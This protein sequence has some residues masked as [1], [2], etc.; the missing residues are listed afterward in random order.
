MFGW[1]KAVSG[2]HV[3]RGI[4]MELKLGKLSLRRTGPITG[5]PH[6][7][8]DNFLGATTFREEGGGRRDAGQGSYH[9]PRE[10][11]PEAVL[12]VNHRQ[13]GD[14]RFDDLHPPPTPPGWQG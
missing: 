5:L 12:G 8:T 9:G 7:T 2:F 14:A 1:G 13:A 4:G 3:V 6:F 10:E 11:T